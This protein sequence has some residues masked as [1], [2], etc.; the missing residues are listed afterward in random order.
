V[1]I[2]TACAFGLASPSVQPGVLAEASIASQTLGERFELRVQQAVRLP[3]AGKEFNV[4]FLR[5]VED[6]RCPVGVT[7]VWEGDAIARLELRDDS[8][9]A[10]IDLHT[11]AGREQAREHGALV[12]RLVRL[13]PVPRAEKPP[14]PDEYVATLVVDRKP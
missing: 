5:V 10:T 7:C 14:Q 6:S 11:H 4:R 8:G 3:L 13:S 2:C 12:V 1:A 9:T